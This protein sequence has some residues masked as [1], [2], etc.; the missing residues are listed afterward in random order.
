M[1]AITATAPGKAVLSGEYAVMDGAPA[2]CMAVNRRAQVTIVDHEEQWHTVISPGFAAVEGRFQVEQGQ[3]E[4]LAGGDAYELFERVWHEVK[5]EPA[6]HASISLDTR[7]FLDAD[8]TAKLGIGSK[9]STLPKKKPP[10]LHLEETVSRIGTLT[11]IDRCSSTVWSI[12][13]S[14]HFENQT[15]RLGFHCSHLALSNDYRQTSYHTRTGSS[16]RIEPISPYN[17]TSFQR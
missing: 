16:S 6:G 17:T 9:R 15:I 2:I 5:P 7:Q 14:R 3:L 8:S 13:A 4:W 11:N 10:P 1:N 12:I